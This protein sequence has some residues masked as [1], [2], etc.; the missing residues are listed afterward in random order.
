[1]AADAD[2]TTPLIGNRNANGDRNGDG[3]GS[4]SGSSSNNGKAASKTS[5]AA[6]AKTAAKT[7][8]GPANRILLAGFLMAFTLGITQV[9]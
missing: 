4:G 2:E 7:V 1:M 8:F 3:S 9:P 6:V 5:T